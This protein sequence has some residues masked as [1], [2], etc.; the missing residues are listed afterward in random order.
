MLNNKTDL[1]NFLMD[2]WQ[3][4]P[5]SVLKNLVGSMRGCCELVIEKEGERIPY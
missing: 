5:D 4:I 3:K 2:E 1:K